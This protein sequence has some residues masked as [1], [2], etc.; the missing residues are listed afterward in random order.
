MKIK[1]NNT[2]IETAAQTV[3]QLASEQQLP[4]KGVAIAINNSMIPR[5]EWEQTPIREG[6]DIVILKAFCGG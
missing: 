6:A 5:T 2:E 3:A 4:Q 1:V